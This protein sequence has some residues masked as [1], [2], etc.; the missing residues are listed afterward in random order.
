ML[1][2]KSGALQE[3]LT[4]EGITRDD[5]INKVKEMLRQFGLED[6]PVCPYDGNGEEVELVGLPSR[7]TDKVIATAA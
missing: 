2:R 3:F 5:V 4:R 6:Y 7:R 1:S